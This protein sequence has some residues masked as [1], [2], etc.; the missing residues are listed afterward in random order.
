MREPRPVSWPKLLSQ[1]DAAHA[2]WK[3]SALAKDV[4]A[5]E[6]S[7]KRLERLAQKATDFAASASPPVRLMLYAAILEVA[8]DVPSL[9]ALVQELWR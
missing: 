4:A 2:S 5:M 6:S 1:I 3:A 7:A 9:R 8:R